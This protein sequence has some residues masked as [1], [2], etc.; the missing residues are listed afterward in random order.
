MV[1]QTSDETWQAYNT[2][3]RQQP[4]H[5]HRQLPAG[6]PAIY[7][8]ASK[9]SY[10]RP[11]HTADDDQGRSWLMYAE[12]PMIRFLEANGY[13]VSLHVRDRRRHV[14]RGRRC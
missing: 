10:N 6:Q 14:R 11:F 9:V 4:L 7:K 8:G 12:Y 13:D 1:F 2:L 3:R 5:L